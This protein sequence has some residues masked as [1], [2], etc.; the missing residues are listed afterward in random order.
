MAPM[1]SSSRSLE[2]PCEPQRRLSLQP[3]PNG[4]VPHDHGCN[5]GLPIAAPS[6]RPT[7]GQAS[8]TDAACLLAPPAAR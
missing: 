1:R 5:D 4:V 6:S 2:D 3:V 7:L 8:T